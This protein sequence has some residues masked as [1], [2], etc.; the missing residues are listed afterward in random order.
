MLDRKSSY[1]LVRDRAASIVSAVVRLDS[2]TKPV[3]GSLFGAVNHSLGV[4]LA[5]RVS[6]LHGERREAP[7]SARTR[8]RSGRGSRRRPPPPGSPGTAEEEGATDRV[9]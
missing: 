7:R 1:E 6:R 9:P 2:A 4:S 5:R 8:D 3:V